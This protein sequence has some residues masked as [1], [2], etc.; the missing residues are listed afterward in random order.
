MS[1]D[2]SLTEMWDEAEFQRMK[3]DGV[4]SYTIEF[5]NGETRETSI[6]AFAYLAR[7]DPEAT[8]Q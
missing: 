3:E 2:E 6:T 7:L 5:E 8:I 1:D 4:E